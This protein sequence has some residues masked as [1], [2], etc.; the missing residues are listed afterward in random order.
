MISGF[1][2]VKKKCIFFLGIFSNTTSIWERN[3]ECMLRTGCLVQDTGY[4]GPFL[5]KMYLKIH[6]N[7]TVFRS[8]IPVFI[9]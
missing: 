2:N 6:K 5:L 9:T 8:A 7:R 3:N 1:L 4:V